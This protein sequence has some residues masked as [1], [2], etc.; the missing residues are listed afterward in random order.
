MGGL[1]TGGLQFRGTLSEGTIRNTTSTTTSLPSSPISR[2][3][4]LSNI[5]NSPSSS[6]TSSIIASKP[7]SHRNQ[8]RG[9]SKNNDP[10]VVTG[11]KDSN[12]STNRQRARR[13]TRIE[14]SNATGAINGNECGGTS[15]ANSSS[16]DMS[17]MQQRVQRVGLTQCLGFRR[18]HLEEIIRSSITCFDH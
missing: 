18:L 4:P 15:V 10:A 8:A 12:S 14:D 17:S 6:T 13:S 2:R 11:T 1:L 7:S 9:A 16:G 5:S 3:T